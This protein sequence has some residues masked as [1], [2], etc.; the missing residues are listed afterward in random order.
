MTM[1]DATAI[2]DTLSVPASE[3]SAR[4][5][6]DSDDVW[7]AVDPAKRRH[8]LVR[9]TGEDVGQHLLATRGLNAS[10][11]S[12]SLE[13]RPV[14]VWVDIVCLDDALANTFTTVASDLVAEVRAHPSNPFEAAQRTLRRWRWFW[15]V[16]PTGMSDEQALGL[17]GE[18]WFLH[19]WATHPQAV[20]TWLGPTGSRH[21]FVSQ[22]LSVEAKAARVRAD[23]PVRHRIASLDQL[24]DPETGELLLFSLTVVNDPNAAN[25]LPG[26]V[27]TIRDQLRTTGELLGL[28]DRRLAESGWTP[29]AAD[30][31]SQTMRVTAEELYRVDHSFPRLTGDTF[32]A[33]LPPGVD[34][35]TY[36]VDLAACSDHLIAT[37]PHEA[38]SL[39]QG[40]H[41]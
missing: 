36:T 39:L 16:D 24:D 32:P 5:H 1:S 19:R 29:A 30:R 10:T 8:L 38:D 23:G 12:L 27:I 6:P 22:S 35:V 4:L 15:G 34:N 25:T 2:W 28:L 18:L 21:D 20:E 3:L 17:F 13:G 41:L 31:H 26:L 9:V 40:L 14:D 37:A 11:E 33:G 7:L